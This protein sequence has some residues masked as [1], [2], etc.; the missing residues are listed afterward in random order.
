MYSLAH[1]KPSINEKKLCTVLSSL[2]RSKIPCYHI[3]C[4]MCQLINY[5]INTCRYYSRSTDEKKTHSPT[6]KFQPVSLLAADLDL[7]S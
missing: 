4:K 7:H 1:K 3:K 2:P 6:S 5:L